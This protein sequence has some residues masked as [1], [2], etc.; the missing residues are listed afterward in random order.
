MRLKTEDSVDET[1]TD[2]FCYN[3]STIQLINRSPINQFNNQPITNTH[4]HPIFAPFLDKLNY[5][6]TMW[7]RRFAECGQIHFI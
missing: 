4:F 2:K 3:N 1:L 6:F 5:G 7:D